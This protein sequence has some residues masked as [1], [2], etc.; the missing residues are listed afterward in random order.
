[1]GIFR[2]ITGLYDLQLQNNQLKDW[3]LGYFR[4]SSRVRKLNLNNNMIEKLPD[5]GFVGLEGLVTLEIRNNSL[6]EFSPAFNRK[7]NFKSS[8]YH[9]PRWWTS[10][11]L[12]A[13]MNHLGTLITISE[14]RRCT[15]L[16]LNDNKIESLEAVYDKNTILCEIDLS[17]NSID[18]VHPEFTTNLKVR[19]DFAGKR[20]GPSAEPWFDLLIQALTNL[21]LSNNRF[22]SLPKLKITRLKELKLKNSHFDCGCHLKV[23][24][25]WMMFC[26]PTESWSV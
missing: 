24:D 14:L 20:A 21:D 5:Y 2:P 23:R 4:E 17:N 6:T 8:K 11:V 26:P 18:R 1:M 15:R 13:L 19:V 12:R 16:Y 22:T 9:W 10:A 25:Q 7:Y 3:K